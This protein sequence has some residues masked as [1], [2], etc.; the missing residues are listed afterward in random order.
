MKKDIY[1]S[2]RKHL[3]L[4]LLHIK[5]GFPSRGSASIHLAYYA[6]NSSASSR[7]CYPKAWPRQVPDESLL[8]RQGIWSSV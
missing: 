8:E 7:V 6:G 3:K 2:I 5:V 4:C 1:T